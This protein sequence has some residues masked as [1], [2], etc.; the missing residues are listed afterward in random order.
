VCSFCALWHYF[1]DGGDIGCLQKKGGDENMQQ[2][3]IASG[4]LCIL[5]ITTVLMVVIM[6]LFWHIFISF[7]TIRE[8]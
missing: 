8:S 4:I 2:T 6:L 5:G 3:G 1:R 7:V